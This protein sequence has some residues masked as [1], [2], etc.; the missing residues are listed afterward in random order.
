[1]SKQLEIKEGKKKRK[2]ESERDIKRISDSTELGYGLFLFMNYNFRCGTRV[3]VD[4]CC[5]HV[6]LRS[7]L[8][9]SITK[10]SR[11]THQTDTDMSIC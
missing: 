5:V 11:N 1:V 8:Q 6:L 7:L 2:K 3:P 10:L 9:L 4:V